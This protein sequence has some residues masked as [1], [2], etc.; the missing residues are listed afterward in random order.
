MRLLHMSNNLKEEVKTILND[1]EAPN[2]AEVDSRLRKAAK[3][4]VEKVLADVQKKM[5]DYD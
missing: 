4:T 5:I 3:E 2:Y 1:F